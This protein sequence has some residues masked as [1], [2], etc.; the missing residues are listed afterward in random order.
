VARAHGTGLGGIGSSYMTM[1]HE[2]DPKFAT[3]GVNK[4][5][6]FVVDTTKAATSSPHGEQRGL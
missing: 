6:C 3:L 5:W 2:A 4:F 1:I